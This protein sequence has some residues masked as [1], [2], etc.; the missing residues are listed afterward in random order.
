[1]MAHTD[2]HFRYLLR[3]ISR[4]V[5]LYTEMITTGALLH[6][7]PGPRLRFNA[8]EHPVGIQLGGADPA[9][10]ARC[11]KMA[12]QEGYDEVNLNVGCP[13]QRV[14]GTGRFGACLIAQ[15]QLVAE[16][17][18]AMR[19]VVR[20]P[21]TVKTRTG[22][23]DRE[24]IETLCAFVGAVRDAGCDA[25]IL[26]ARK[27]WL[28]GLSPRQN[29]Q[30]PPLRYDL[31]YAVKRAFPALPLIINGGIVTQ[32]QIETQLQKVDGV[33]IGRAV[34]DNPWLLAEAGRRVFNDP[35]TTP[36]RGAVLEAYV[37]YAA[38][39]IGA[40][41][42]LNHLSRHA[43]GLFQGRPGARLY[44]RHLSERS[45]LPG[46]G[47]EVMREATRLVDSSL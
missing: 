24:D 47:I 3:L 1:M 46:A 22:I 21:V 10:L 35:D 44:R 2:R 6:G 11:A 25:L 31:A 15:P 39:E 38:R 32:E 23:D 30:V 16:C 18:A 26:H 27:A 40:G 45:V 29:R 12:E 20:I 17:V 14:A 41:A 8:A 13:S 36:A 5:M 33:M 7:D 9:E 42:R 28:N 19:A 43:L 37:D 4:R 34:C